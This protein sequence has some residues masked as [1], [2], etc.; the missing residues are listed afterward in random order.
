[1]SNLVIE[2]YRNP[3]A[4][5]LFSLKAWDTFVRQSRKANLLASFY[6]IFE[7]HGLL[8]KIPSKP[9]THLQAAHRFADKHATDI[10][11]EIDKLSKAFDQL[12]QPLVLLKGAA[13][14]AAKLPNCTGRVFQDTDILVAETALTKVENKLNQHGWYQAQITAYDE[15]YYRRWSHELPP[16]R[17]LQRKSLLDVHH[18]IVQPTAS[19]NPSTTKLLNSIQ[20]LPAS[21]VFTL[22][23]TD[24][25]LHSIVHLFNDGEFDH[26]LRDLIDIDQL[27]RHFNTDLKLPGKLVDRAEQL[28]LERPLYYAMRYLRLVFDAGYAD[29][30]ECIHVKQKPNAVLIRLM[31]HLFINAIEGHHPSCE[32]KGADLAR[33]C[34]YVRAHYLRMPLHR[35]IPH[36]LYKAFQTESH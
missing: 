16:M 21:N 6:T 4:A 8:D 14:L 11:W 17:H 32:R 29:E 9:K 27:I 33:W 12:E 10:R 22:A 35:L 2:A 24:M 5:T 7:N 3:E 13:Y 36:L 28:D 1:M 23:P 20:Q 34:L 30:G 31:D 18:R 19:L 25:I 15:R 26:A